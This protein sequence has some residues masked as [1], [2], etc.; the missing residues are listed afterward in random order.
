MAFGSDDGIVGLAAATAIALVTAVLVWS[1]R[2]P[3]LQLPPGPK[4]LP[5]IG[6][7]LEW[8]THKE[9]V[10]FTQWHARYGDIV[11]ANVLG[12]KILVLNSP[13]TAKALLD[14]RGSIYSDRPYKRFLFDILGYQKSPIFCNADHPYFKPSHRLIHSAVGSRAALE[15]SSSLVA[16]EAHRFLLRVIDSPSNVP[17]LLRK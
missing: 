16:Y 14:D 7:L 15:L 11:Y 2:R 12:T 5:L 4:G 1:S 13:A 6:S 3:R 17:F 9:W 8:P 10:T